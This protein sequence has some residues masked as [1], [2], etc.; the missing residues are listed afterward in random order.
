MGFFDKLKQLQE[1]QQKMEESRKRLEALEV[2]SVNEYVKIVA[3]GDRKIKRVEIL[4]TDDVA[5][6]QHQLTAA[7]NDVLAKA[8]SAMQ[9]EMKGY[10]P[11]LPGLG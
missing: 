1:L 6:L 11:N 3:T 4:K 2:E 7:L 9:Q 5:A 10:L 8:D